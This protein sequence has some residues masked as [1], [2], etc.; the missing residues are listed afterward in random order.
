MRL[1]LSIA[2]L[3]L[4]VGIRTSAA[5]EQSNPQATITALQTQ[6]AILGSQVSATPLTKVVPATPAVQSSPFPSLREIP[7]TG[8]QRYGPLR[9][10]DRNCSL[11][12]VE[13]VRIRI[14][15]SGIDARVEAVGIV[16]GVM[17][18]PPNTAVVAWY[19]DLAALGECH[20][21]VVLAG[22]YRTNIV[23]PAV[24]SRLNA[25]HRGDEIEVVGSDGTTYVYAVESVR[26]FDDRERVPIQQV[27]GRSAT[28]SLTLMTGAEPYDSELGDYRGMTVVRADLVEE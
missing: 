16:N 17:Q 11:D 24:F 26:T 18:D 19:S 13:P 4:L 1:V 25:L 6:V 3:F 8:S 14:A 9:Q 22:N 12:G 20:G 28:E 5:Q 15:A 2:A 23:D 27:V 7:T 21:N 10:T